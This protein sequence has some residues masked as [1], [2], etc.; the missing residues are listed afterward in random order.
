MIFLL[1]IEVQFGLTDNLVLISS[2]QMSVI[3]TS[4]IHKFTVEICQLKLLFFSCLKVTLLY[5][6]D[7]NK[8]FLTV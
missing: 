4:V 6:G 8:S 5:K 2:Q 3:F 7:F 1:K